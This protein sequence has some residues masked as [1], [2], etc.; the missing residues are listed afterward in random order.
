MISYARARLQRI[1]ARTS[2]ALRSGSIGAGD[3][4]VLPFVMTAPDNED[5]GCQRARWTARCPRAPKPG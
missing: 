1:T 2:S 3:F 5:A 4:D